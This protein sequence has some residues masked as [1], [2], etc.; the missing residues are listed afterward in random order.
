MSIKIAVLRSGDQII[1]D[2]S[3]MTAGDDNTNL[4]GYYFF[5]PCVIQL[6][7]R[8]VPILTGEQVKTYDMKMYPWIP[9]TEDEKIPIPLD[10]VTTFV[11]PVPKA[12]KM[13]ENNVLGKGWTEGRPSGGLSEDEIQELEDEKAELEANKDSD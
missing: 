5:K 1:T 10:H 6:N 8:K 9:L 12:Y 3:D 2:V 4:V 11:E 7:E 13:Y